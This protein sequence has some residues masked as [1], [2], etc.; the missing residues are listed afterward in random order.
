[1]K[2]DETIRECRQL[3]HHPLAIDD[4]M[5]LVSTV[6]LIKI[7]ERVHNALSPLEGPVLPDHIDKIRQADADFESWYKIWDYAFSKK[8]PDA[9]AYGWPAVVCIFDNL[10]HHS[11]L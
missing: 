4:D 2:D 8:W 9:G 1:M 6:E 11:I 5:R 10:Y 7:R 3:L